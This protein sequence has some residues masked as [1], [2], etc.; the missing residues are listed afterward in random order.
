MTHLTERRQVDFEMA[1]SLVVHVAHAHGDPRLTSSADEAIFGRVSGLQ[2]L[3]HLLHILVV[4]LLP[5]LLRLGSRPDVA[6]VRPPVEGLGHGKHHEDDEDP[7]ELHCPVHPRLGL[8]GPQR[9]LE[10]RHAANSQEE[11]RPA[12]SHHPQLSVTP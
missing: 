3:D 4:L 9:L 5:L 2:P 1:S 12:S 7:S 6:E 11:D 10:V 8:L